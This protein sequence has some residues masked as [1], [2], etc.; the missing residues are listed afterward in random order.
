MTSK[1][2]LLSGARGRMGQAIQSIAGEHQC[3]ISYPVDLGDDPRAYMD[4]CD[5]VIDFSL[6]DATLPLAKIAAE[7]AKPMVIGTTGHEKTVRD[8]I[9]ALTDKIPMVWAG[10][11]STGVNL[12]FYLTEQASR[13]LNADSDFDPEV[14]EMHHRLKK[15][16]PSGT[17]D[18]LLEILKESR[19]LSDEN[20]AHGRNG[21]VGER[22]R[23]EIGSHAI[24]GGD[25]VGEH[26]VM[27][28]GM[29]ERIELTHRAT[30]R[31][32]FAAGALRASK[33]VIPQDAGLYS[34][35]DVL[36]LKS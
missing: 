10:N 2:I 15:D 13:V 33:W 25:I 28:A 31:I 21:M 26:T 3:E 16:A 5:V 32:I 17:A 30:D 27:F 11:F 29:G 14:L 7:F 22:P 24:R 36:G 34:M 8:E 23:N 19:R 18:R 12:L 20:L 35:Q 4:S 9:V 1:K 6:R